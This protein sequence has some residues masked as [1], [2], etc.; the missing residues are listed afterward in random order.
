MPDHLRTC[1]ETSTLKWTFTHAYY[2][3]K[4]FEEG[5][6]EYVAVSFGIHLSRQSYFPSKTPNIIYFL[7]KTYTIFTELQTE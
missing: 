1:Q 4:T 2:D 6:M 3:Y 5:W 7:S